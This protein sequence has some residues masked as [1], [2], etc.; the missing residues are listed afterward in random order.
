MSKRDLLLEIGTEEIPAASVVIGNEQL[1]ERAEL[2]FNR[3]RLGFD[4]IK[5]YG[6]P[7]RLTL[8]ATG[9]DE[10]QAKVVYEVRGPAKKVAYTA[11]GQPTKAAIGFAKS[12]GVEVESLITKI[13]EGREYVFA[14]KEEEGREA[15]DILVTILPEFILSLSFPKA[16]RWGDG[17]VRF[18]RPIRWIVALFG[19]EV[20]P[21]TLDGI[22]SDRHSMGHRFLADNPIL[23]KKPGDYL[24]TLEKS[25]VI[26]D[27]E[28]RSS[29]IKSEIENAVED[30]G[31]RA[32]IHEHTFDEVLQ[33]VEYPHAI[34]GS[35]SNEFVSLPRDVLVTAM[36]SHQRYFPVEDAGGKLLPNFVVVHNG[37]PGLTELIQKGHERVIRA[38]LADAKFFFESDSLKPLESYVDKLKG[39]IFQSKLGTVYQKTRRL[40]KLSDKIARNLGLAQ[41]E[42]DHAVRAAYLSKADL[43]TGMVGEFPTLQGVMG[44]EYALVSGE[45]EQVAIGIFE[46]YLPRSAG[47]ILPRTITGQVVSIA[48]KLDLIIGILAVGL[49]PTGSE[50]P[51]ALR[52]QAYG[53]VSI[54]LEN[55][56]NIAMGKLI[57]SALNLYRDQGVEFDF[58]ITIGLVEDFIRGRLRAYLLAR[59]LP[60][61][62]IEAAADRPIDDM[63]D[64]RK[65]AEALNEKLDSKEMGDALVAFTRC[66]NLAKLELG[67]QLNT[68]LLQEEAEKEL[69]ANLIGIDN[70]I[71]RADGDYLLSIDILARLRGPVDRFFD[72]VLVMAKD[73]AIKN[74]RIRLLNYCVNV[75][76][77]VADF[78]Y[79]SPPG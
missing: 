48:D 47:D 32:V 55:N 18:V 61:D 36:E 33:L 17:E 76:R 30:T 6:A 79:I 53:I 51:Y 2:L 72:E 5:T 26:A 16:M 4:D 20:I 67:T 50:D 70:D 74:N 57:E 10:K 19:D 66:K 60:A 63:I 9:L 34:R 31:G 45:P 15:I 38:R 11:D 7:R 13:H 29:I 44:R 65:R 41:H 42:V 69:Y 25:K 62:V 1:K 43:V 39:V 22:T 3:H 54:V 28:R 23:I 35:F 52:R 37:N 8:L 14:I 58:A 71:E 77:K 49:I 40:V 78:S 56:V 64:I 12:Q 68:N 46:H 27:Q 75:F 21:F 59:Q 73:E 24:D